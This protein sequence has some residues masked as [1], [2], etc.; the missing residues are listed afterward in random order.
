MKSIIG[1][2]RRS[3]V[4]FHR[5]GRID[6]T[7]RVA[8]MLSLAKGDVIDIAEHQGEYYLYVMTRGGMAMGGYEGTCYPTKR[9]SRNFRAYSV[10]L[11]RA[12][13]Q[14]NAD[15]RY[16]VGAP[17]SIHSFGVCIPIITLNPI[18]K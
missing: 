5:N 12:I 8:I 6:I 9:R 13:L 2:A 10:R 3:D 7:S 15:A 14:G 18:I 16:P 17:V 1:Q 11:C 4:A